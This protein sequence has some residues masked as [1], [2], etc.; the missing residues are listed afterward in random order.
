M[1]SLVG[2]SKHIGSYHSLTYIHTYIER[3]RSAREMN[4]VGGERSSIVDKWAPAMAVVVA[5]TVTGSVNALVKKALDGGVNHMVIGAYR[6]AI[7]AFILAP[8]AY[9]LERFDI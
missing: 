1:G 9:F 4:V 8:L 5:N 2:N 7:S 3:K 6:L